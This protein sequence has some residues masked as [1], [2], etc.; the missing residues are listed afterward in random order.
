[1]ATTLTQ[2]RTRVRRRADFENNNFISD[3][4]LTG[5][6]NSSYQELYDLLVSSFED[7]FVGDPTS[8]AVASGS[9]TYTL[10]A[11][12][13]KLVG[14][15]RLLSGNDYYPLRPF[16]FMDRNNRR[17][18]QRVRGLYNKVSYRVLGSVIRFTPE[19]QAEGSY[20]IWYVPTLTLLS[21]DS[22]EILSTITNQGWEEY[23][24]VDAA[25]K[26]LQKEESDVQVLM[27]QK[28]ALIRRVEEMAK[29]RDIGDCDRITDVTKSG[30][31]DPFFYR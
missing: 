28:Q 29:N 14:L 9:S 15:D 23:I 7:Y 21:A 13:Y 26:C 11:D 22:D 17:L 12:F 2:M 5:F 31:D 19:D 8:F 20:R 24:E 3:A 4:E 18:V 30:Y 25:I 1:M 27:M 16:N 10:P 6:I